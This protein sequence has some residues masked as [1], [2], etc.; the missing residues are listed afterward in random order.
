[1]FAMPGVSV[2]SAALGAPAQVS[3]DKESYTPGERILVTIV[4]NRGRIA[5]PRYLSEHDGLSLPPMDST[6]SADP[7]AYQRHP[8][9]SLEGEPPAR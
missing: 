9:A 1:M 6:L 2:L 7:S 5:E 3:L 8:R 4:V